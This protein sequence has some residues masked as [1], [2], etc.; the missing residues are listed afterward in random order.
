MHQ[1]GNM[2]SSKFLFLTLPALPNSV[3]VAIL[4]W[5]Q[6]VS[7]LTVLISLLMVAFSLGIGV[8]L[9]TRHTQYAQNNGRPVHHLHAYTAEI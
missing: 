2:N 6:G 5:L 1:T 8:F 3:G 4:I 7:L 9:W